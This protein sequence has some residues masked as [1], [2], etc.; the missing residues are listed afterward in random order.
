MKTLKITSKADGSVTIINKANIVFYEVR[1]WDEAGESTCI[2]I[3]TN[4]TALPKMRFKRDSADFGKNADIEA[5]LASLECGEIIVS[6]E[7]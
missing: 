6:R 4:A 1:E 5:T 2:E 3:Y 7:A